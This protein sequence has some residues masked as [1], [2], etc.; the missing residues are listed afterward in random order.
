[1][2]ERDIKVFKLI[3]GEELVAYATERMA[4]NKT[5][6]ILEKP[7]VMQV[8]ATKQGPQA[9]LVPW[10]ISAPDATFT[11][12]EDKYF[13]VADAPKDVSDYYM[14]ITSGLKLASSLN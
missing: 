3:N 9:G 5:E 14:E 10:M 11:L 1:M 13:V 12:S 7:R 4:I 2:S 8:M 6:Y